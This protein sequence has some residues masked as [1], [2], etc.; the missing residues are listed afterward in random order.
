MS[1]CT[2]WQL[3]D[4]R[5]EDATLAWWTQAEEEL[6]A[7][8]KLQTVSFLPD[9][10]LHARGGKLTKVPVEKSR[11]PHDPYGHIQ[12]VDTALGPDGAVYVN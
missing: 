5:T 3:L 8:Q 11:L 1:F 4:S 6:A 7:M 9:Y 12:I 2:V 10:I